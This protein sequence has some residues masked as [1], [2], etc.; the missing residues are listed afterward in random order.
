MKGKNQ[1]IEIPVQA[2]FG[3]KLDIRIALF[4]IWITLC[5]CSFAILILT[6]SF[7][8]LA[9][10]IDLLDEGLTVSLPVY[11][12]QFPLDWPLAFIK[13]PALE[14]NNSDWSLEYR[15]DSWFL[16]WKVTN[17]SRWKRAFRLSYTNELFPFLKHFLNFAN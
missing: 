7:S 8:N 9:L 17:G 2:C 11:K 13:R 4:V 3:P 6:Q 12:R 1:P 10:P 5:P 14:R 16:T 15:I